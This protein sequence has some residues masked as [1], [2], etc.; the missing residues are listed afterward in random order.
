MSVLTRKN[1]FEIMLLKCMEKHKRVYAFDN[2]NQY[3]DKNI[4]D[5]AVSENLIFMYPECN[6]YFPQGRLGRLWVSSKP[7]I[8]VFGT[9]SRQG[10]SCHR[11]SLLSNALGA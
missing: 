5:K 4:L 8:G 11:Y 10:K 2:V 3:V 9:S 1:L 6:V 7:V